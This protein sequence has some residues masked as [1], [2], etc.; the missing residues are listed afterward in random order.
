MARGKRRQGPE[1]EGIEEFE[2]SKAR[3]EEREAIVEFDERAGLSQGLAQVDDSE[4]QDSGFEVDP[5]LEQALGECERRF[6]GAEAIMHAVEKPAT[7]RAA[8]LENIVGWGIGLKKVGGRLSGEPSVQVFVAEKLRSSEISAATVVPGEIGGYPTDVEEVGDVVAQR[9][10]GRQRP[11]RGGSSIG[12]PEVTAGTL[13]CL[14][15]RN[16]N[17]LCLLS[18]NHVIAN[19]NNAQFGDPILQPGRVDGGHNPQDRI[20]IL[21]SFIPINFN[22]TNFVDAA[23]G[24]TNFNSTSGHH[25]CY[26]INTTPRN[27]FLFLPV[28][29]CGR[30][31]QHTLGMVVGVRVTIRVNFGT[32]GV[33]VFAN[34]MSIRGLGGDFSLGG[35]S[36]SLVIHASTRQPVG[37]LFAGGGG[38]TIANPIAAVIG[39]LGISR[40]LNAP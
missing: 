1:S 3:H 14:V 22:G 11:A 27:H 34:Q 38:L 30:T 4:D 40:F 21:E 20:G 33:A 12:H 28:R 9:F 25:H 8:G 31:T 39:S 13:G 16:N 18:N 32:A 10:T 7:A 17:R 15:V 36:G 6:G 19:S 26:Q 35:D 23:L 29:K 2:E 24:W 37:L 5:G